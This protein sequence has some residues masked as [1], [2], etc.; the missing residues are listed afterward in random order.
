[1]SVA[2][3]AGCGAT[4]D[5]GPTSTVSITAVADDPSA[6]TSSNGPATTPPRATPP[7]ST[8]AP[9][10]TTPPA[11]TTTVGT[12]TTSTGDFE[13][14][15]PA[16]TFET[17]PADLFVLVR[18]GDLELWSGALTSTTPQRTLVADYPDPFAVSEEGPGP[19]VI[20]HVAGEIGGTVVF[21]DCCE[22]I[23]GNVVAATAVGDAAPIAGGFTP[24]L[25]PMG[26]LLGTANG[27]LISQT[28]ADSTG[29]GRYRQ[30]NQQPQQSYLNVADLTWSSND[31]AAADDDHMVLLAWDD[32]GW[33]LY[34]VDR[35]TLEPTP[36]LALGVPPVSEAPDTTMDFVGHGPNSEIVVAQGTPDTTRLRSFDPTTL[37]ERAPLERSLPGSASS[38]RLADDGLGLLWVDGGSLYHLRAGDVEAVRLGTDIL[39]A[40]FA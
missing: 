33:W 24:T 39:A 38:I 27:N 30:L 11:A 37:A 20:D 7:P 5:A 1:M 29:A 4:N 32:D 31:T 23:S 40:W 10:P 17:G 12:A 35:S 19:N 9:A 15:I 28:A 36:T 21:G 14:P 3:A 6:P 13:L 2:L 8:T 18:S 34:D 26:D 25:S 16:G 22:P